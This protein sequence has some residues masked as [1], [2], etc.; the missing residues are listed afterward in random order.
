MINT[1]INNNNYENNE[2]IQKLQLHSTPND[3]HI[4][5]QTKYSNRILN[6]PPS[7]L[8]DSLQYLHT[9]GNSPKLG[10]QIL[11]HNNSTND[12]STNLTNNNSISLNLSIHTAEEFGKEMLAW[13]QNEHKRNN[14]SSNLTTSSST[15]AHHLH[16]ITTNANDSS[17]A[18]TAATLV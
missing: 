15:N 12:V 5:L 9:N 8:Y 10:Y 6:T 11:S 4:P 13:L 3:S 17:T 7:S 16:H 14:S 1:A 18:T 2:Q